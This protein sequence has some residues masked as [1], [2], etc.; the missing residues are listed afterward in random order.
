MIVNRENKVIA[1]EILNDSCN[2]RFKIVHV[3]IQSKWGPIR[4]TSVEI[5]AI[6]IASRLVNTAIWNEEFWLVKMSKLSS[7]RSLPG[8][9]EGR[10]CI[11]HFCSSLVISGSNS[12]CS[13]RA[14][15]KSSM[16]HQNIVIF[17]PCKPHQQFPTNSFIA[18]DVGS[19][20][21]L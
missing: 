17:W 6:S 11:S 4:E 12:Y 15:D 3:D 10:R 18:M 5:F 7:Y 19:E 14:L 1:V 9:R 13:H 8:L 2:L 21:D 20:S 16:S